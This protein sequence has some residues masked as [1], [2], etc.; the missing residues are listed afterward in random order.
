MKSPLLKTQRKNNRKKRE[1]REGKRRISRA[2]SSSQFKENLR[3]GFERDTQLM[4]WLIAESVC[5]EVARFLDVELPARYVVWLD[6]KAE[7]CYSTRRHFYKL[8]RGKG[9][10][11]RD[12]LYCFMRHWLASLLKLER[13][14]LYH[15]LPENFGNG[16]RL[17]PGTHPRIPRRS[18]V[19]RLPSPRKWD[20]RRVLQN[21]RWHWAA[22]YG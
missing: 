21:H 6:A 11:G 13:L 2:T 22:A 16:R 18:F 17:P 12:W 10:R 15:C 4:P 9:N 20:E 3:P 1:D 14:D 7:R 19:A 8:M 5:D